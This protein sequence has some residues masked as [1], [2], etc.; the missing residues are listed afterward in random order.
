MLQRYS[1]S[2]IMKGL[3]DAIEEFSNR[4]INIIDEHVYIVFNVDNNVNDVN[5]NVNNVNT[6][7]NN[8]VYRPEDLDVLRTLLD[9]WASEALKDLQQ[10]LRKDYF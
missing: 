1:S 8:N 3:H 4:V 6:F 10:V 7:V 9:D 2:L 5:N